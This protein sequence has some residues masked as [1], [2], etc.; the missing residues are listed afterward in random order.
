MEPKFTT[1]PDGV[2]TISLPTEWDWLTQA[3][4]DCFATRPPKGSPDATSSTYWIDRALDLMERSD[5]S[6]I[7]LASGNMSR[8]SLAETTV[9]ASADYDTFAD[10]EMPTWVF[11][12]LLKQWRAA[13]LIAGSQ[14]EDAYDD[15]YPT[16]ALTYA[17]LRVFSEELSPAAITFLLEADPTGGHT[18]GDPVG[19]S[20]GERS[21]NAWILASEGSVQ[22]DDLARHIDW[23][24]DEVNEIELRSLSQGRRAQVDLFCY[25][26]SFSGHGGPRLEPGL[27]LRLANLGLP[28]GVDVYFPG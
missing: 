13:T 22:S 16:C 10:Y 18:K 15:D 21:T 28:V 4:E 5:G 3:L 24:L 7:E 19:R 25:W 20:G 23:V 9:T 6:T 27:M 12:G 1:Q 2:V 14:L 26:E 8:F 11:S 17:S